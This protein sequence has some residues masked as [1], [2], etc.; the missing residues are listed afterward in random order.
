MKLYIKSAT[1]ISDLEAK[2][3]KKEEDIRKKQQLITKRNAAID[4][5]L[6]ILDK[7]LNSS[8][9]NHINQY[10]DYATE[11]GT[12]KMPE[13]L[14][15]WQISRDHDSEFKRDFGFADDPIYKIRDAVDSI[16]NANTAIKEYQ[17]TL[18]KYNAQLDKIKQKEKEID[19]IPEV[20]KDFMN[21]I[22]DRWD[23]YD[24]N[25]RDTSKPIYKELLKESDEL[26]YGEEGPYRSRSAKTS[27]AKLEELYPNVTSYRR[28]TQFKEDYI[29]TP[30]RKK[31][32]QS[33]QYCSSLWSMSDEDIHKE[34]E[35]A[36]KNLILDLLNRV[37]KI[38]GPVVDWSELYITRGNLGAV[39]NGVVIGEDGKAKV[40]SIYASGPI[41]RL[42]IRTL[43][44]PIK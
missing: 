31:V 12:Y 28:Y 29:N 4:K 10:I 15:T 41:Q 17:A 20:L 5:Q 27:N 22:I 32:G 35:R 33:V 44:K 30:F 19:E 38:T 1:N 40:E 6:K 7:Y 16:H 2:I 26:L 18:D 36:G 14:N 3:A 25:L 24:I 34:N 9:I 42:H 11:R 23:E 21:E 8:E 39:I 43:V 37:T 13:N